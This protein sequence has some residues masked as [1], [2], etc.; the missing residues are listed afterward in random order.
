MQPAAI[1]GVVFGLVAVPLSAG[2]LRRWVGFRSDPEW[3]ARAESCQERT[4]WTSMRSGWINLNNCVRIHRCDGG[5]LLQL[6]WI[7]GGGWRW[8]PR[9]SVQD[10]REGRFLG[11]WR[12]VTVVTE[13]R[14]FRFMG[15]G[16]DLVSRWWGEGAAV[17]DKPVRD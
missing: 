13:E 7:I 6:M 10:V 16:A 1:L 8:I 5:I 15:S 11:L 12:T 2:L 9:E 14:R 4:R 3:A 17:G